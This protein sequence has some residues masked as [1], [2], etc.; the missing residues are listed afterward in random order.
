MEHHGRDARQLRDVPQLQWHEAL[1]G[2]PEGGASSPTRPS[3]PRQLTPSA[4]GQRG[5]PTGPPAQD[6]G[7]RE[8]RGSALT[9][10]PRR[11]PPVLPAVIPQTAPCPPGV[12]GGF[13]WTESVQWAGLFII[14]FILCFLALIS[15]RIPLDEAFELWQIDVCPVH[16]FI[17]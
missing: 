15:K 4:E 12:H 6:G 5:Q 8:P 7:S 17:G 1:P 2:L 14:K 3:A 16:T 13:S 9:L 11:T 10:P